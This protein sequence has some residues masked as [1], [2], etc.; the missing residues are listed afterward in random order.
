MMLLNRPQAPDGF[1]D[2]VRG[3]RKQVEAAVKFG[4]R[5]V[6]EERLWREHKAEFS[7]AQHGKCGYCESFVIGPCVG[8][9]EHYRPKAE[10]TELDD[11]PHTWGQELPGLANVTGRKPRP[12]CDQGYWWLAYEWS[13]YLLACERCNRAWKGS[14]FPIRNPRSLPPAEGDLEGPLLLNPFEKERPAEHLRYDDLGQ[15][16]AAR[17]SPLGFET[18]RTVGLDRESLRA[19]REEKAKRIHALIRQLRAADS[20]DVKQILERIIE[21]GDPRYHHS[22]MVRIIFERLTALDWS[23]LESLNG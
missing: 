1:A 12:L 2:K 14:L 10:I 16:E 21:L 6:F 22:G 11:D 13:N 8:D 7:R 9:V 19:A 20:D 5:P 15:V 23:E 3:A 18:I 4:D 17:N